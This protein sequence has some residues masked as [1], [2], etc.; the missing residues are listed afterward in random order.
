MPI[1][2]VA[3]LN[4]DPSTKQGKKSHE[5]KND[6]EA[7]FTERSSPLVEN[8]S[9]H[10]TKVWDTQR[11]MKLLLCVIVQIRMNRVR[12][13]IGAQP[14]KDLNGYIEIELQ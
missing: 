2:Y 8:L 1:W 4:F 6:Y 11:H 12:R 5:T 14:S 13:N 3:P 7:P 10:P 9:S